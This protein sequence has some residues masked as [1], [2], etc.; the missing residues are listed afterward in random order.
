MSIAK[1]ASTVGAFM[2]YPSTATKVSA[3]TPKRLVDAA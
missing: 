2:P 1:A 3:V